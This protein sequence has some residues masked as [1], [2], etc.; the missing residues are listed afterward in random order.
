MIWEGQG[1]RWLEQSWL[2]RSKDENKEVEGG[3]G[4]Q[5]AGLHKNFKGFGFD[6]VN[7]E[8]TGGI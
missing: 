3:E 2:R 6:S 7:W 4:G 5:V 8:A 1:G